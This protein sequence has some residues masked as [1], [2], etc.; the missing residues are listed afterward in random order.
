MAKNELSLE[1]D[2]I[3]IRLDFYSADDALQGQKKVFLSQYANVPNVK[4]TIPSTGEELHKYVWDYSDD[5]DW[6]YLRFDY[7]EARFDEQTIRIELLG[8]IFLKDEIQRYFVQN[9]PLDYKYEPDSDLDGIKDV[10]DNDD[11]GDG[12]ED[13]LDEFLLTPLSLLILMEMALEIT[14]ILMRTMMA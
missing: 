13:Q 5:G 7:L 9:H 2:Y 4:V 10:Q 12:I 8:D 11:D 1:P 14:Q 3:A 6:L